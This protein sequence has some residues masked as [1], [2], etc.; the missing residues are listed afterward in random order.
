MKAM[1]LHVVDSC[2]CGFHVYKDIWTPATGE[3]LS[4]EREDR[5]LMDPYAVA[6]Q[7]GS[8]VIEHIP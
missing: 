1:V 5:N 8:K 4:C 6:I 2:V 7:R 3:V